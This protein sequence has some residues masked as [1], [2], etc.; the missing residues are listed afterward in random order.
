VQCVSPD[1]CAG[2]APDVFCHQRRCVECEVSDDCDPE[3]RY[4]VGY[5]CIQCLSDR[6]CPDNQFCN[7]DGRCQ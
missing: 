5:R 6:E 1:D 4:C 3:R 2:R 7:N